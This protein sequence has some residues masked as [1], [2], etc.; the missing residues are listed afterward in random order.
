MATD[1]AAVGI[2][3]GCREPP[4]VFFDRYL[5]GSDLK[6][7]LH[8]WSARNAQMLRKQRNLTDLVIVRDVP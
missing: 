4:F 3:S 1:N 8:G 6:S 7:S 5:K 2:R